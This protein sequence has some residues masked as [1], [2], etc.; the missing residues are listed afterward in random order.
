MLCPHRLDPIVTY[1]VNQ[2]DALLAFARQLD[3]DLAAVAPDF[4]V[5]V[6]VPRALLQVQE[7]DVGTGAAG[8]RR[9]S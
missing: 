2:R 9:P 1:L 7:R 5:P 8:L 4:Q 6:A 3:A